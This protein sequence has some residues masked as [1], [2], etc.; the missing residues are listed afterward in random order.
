MA[1]LQQPIG[2]TCLA[3]SPARKKVVGSPRQS[4]SRS[5]ADNGT[6]VC[7]AVSQAVCRTKLK[8]TAISG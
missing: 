4:L 1:G 3:I 2:L 5:V 8:T 7:Q 6:P